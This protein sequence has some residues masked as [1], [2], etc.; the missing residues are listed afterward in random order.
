MMN[1]FQVISLL[2]DLSSDGKKFLAD[3]FDLFVEFISVE[4]GFDFA[5]TIKEGKST[6]LTREN[7]FRDH[8]EM[9]YLALKSMEL[10]L[11][12]DFD[13]FLRNLS[14]DFVLTFDDDAP[15]DIHLN[16]DGTTAYFENTVIA[17]F[18]N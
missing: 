15:G 7:L 2:K 1:A 12:K 4:S 18:P 13:A 16:W 5:A 11:E 9:K 6:S 10:L 3:N 17:N 8:L 14:L